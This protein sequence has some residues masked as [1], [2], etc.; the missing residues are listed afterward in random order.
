MAHVQQHQRAS[1]ALQGLE[2][3]QLVG[4]CRHIK[5]DGAVGVAHEAAQQAALVHACAT[6]TCIGR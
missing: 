5:G 4:G 3:V 1:R 6:C 2:L